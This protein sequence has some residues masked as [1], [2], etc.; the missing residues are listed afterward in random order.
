MRGEEKIPAHLFSRLGRTE[1]YLDNSILIY[2]AHSYCYR[3]EREQH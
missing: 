1:L 2:H 3:D